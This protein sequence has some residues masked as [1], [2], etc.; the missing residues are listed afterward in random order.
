MKAIR[1]CLDDYDLPLIGTVL[2][3]DADVQ[4]TVENLEAVAP[5]AF[6]VELLD[7]ESLDV[8]IAHMR[9]IVGTEDEEVSYNG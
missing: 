2:V 4:S 7:D 6:V 8:I 5:G 1:V 3:E 9:D